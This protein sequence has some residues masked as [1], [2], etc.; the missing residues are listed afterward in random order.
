[1]STSVDHNRAETGG[2]HGG[3]TV[4]LSPEGDLDARSVQGLRNDLDAVLR[5]DTV[6]TVVIDLR[7]V[8]FVDSSGLGA[9]I[10]A[11]THADVTGTH[12][13]LRN[14]ATQLRRLMAITGAQDAF[15]WA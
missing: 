4:H 15:T 13:V 8:R 10:A 12:L 3:R 14:P 1:M 9:L 7:L 6:A 2:E 5:D 11:R